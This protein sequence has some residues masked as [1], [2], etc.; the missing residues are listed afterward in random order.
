MLYEALFIICTSAGPD[1]QI[2]EI[3]YNNN[4]YGDL[5]ILFKIVF[6][7]F[8]NMHFSFYAFKTIYALFVLTTIYCLLANNSE[9]IAFVCTIAY[10]FPLTSFAG[11]IRNA[12]SI[13][14]VLLGIVYLLKSESRYKYF[15]YIVIIIFASLVHKSS[16]VY[17]VALPATI[18]KKR[19]FFVLTVLI[20]TLLIFIAYPTGVLFKFI[21]LLTNDARILKWV[22]PIRGISFKV[23]LNL[24]FIQL[25]GVFLL[26]VAKN[27]L[28]RQKICNT[29]SIKYFSQSQVD[30]LLNINIALFFLLPLYYEGN[31]YFRIFKY[32]LILNYIPIVQAIFNKKRNHVL[33][34]LLVLYSLGCQIM[35]YRIETWEINKNVFDSFD[36]NN[37]VKIL[38][39]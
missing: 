35:I 16:I 9:Y 29:V 8:V 25:I 1:V 10:I 34:L 20:F 32:I 33:L 37:I 5:P 24:T 7:F 6:D 4:L 11:Q 12:M 18:D 15:F 17:L 21:S 31:A 23:T 39:R 38:E 13:V 36:L 3:Q 19:D 27:E 22:R 28:I 26:L 2:Y 30:K 14:I